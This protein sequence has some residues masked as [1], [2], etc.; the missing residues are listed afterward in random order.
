MKQKFLIFLLL[1]IS[2]V[3]LLSF[4]AG[5]ADVVD[6][7]A[8]D[9]RAFKTEITVPV[10]DF[11]ALMKETFARYPELSYIYNKSTYQFSE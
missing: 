5:A 1:I 7:F 3:A 2:M 9:M 6:D 8:N 10:R 11:D 4:N